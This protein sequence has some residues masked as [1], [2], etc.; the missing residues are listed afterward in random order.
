MGRIITREC[1]YCG[2][3][4]TYE[5]G[6]GRARKYCCYACQ[7]KATINS[8]NAKHPEKLSEYNQKGYMSGEIINLYGGKC[9]ICGWKM[10][11]E[12]IKTDTGYQYARGNEIHHITPVREGGTS[13]FD[14][15]ILLCPNHHKQA[16]AGILDRET[17]RT[18]LKALPS[19]EERQEMKNRS[20]ARISAAIFGS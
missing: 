18:Y 15:L 8:R 19:E 11:E 2:T 17:L 5:S 13:G 3:A 14:N 10:C 6:G 16:D 9:A 20:T 12:I 1:A 7:R 4:F